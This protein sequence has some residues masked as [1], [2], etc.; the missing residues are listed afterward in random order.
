MS[1]AAAT[2]GLPRKGGIVVASNA[3]AYARIMWN[4]YC[5][6]GETMFEST[7]IGMDEGAWDAL[8][9]EGVVES[10]NTVK[11]TVI[12]DPASAQRYLNL[13]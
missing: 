11:G 2:A 5:E 6:T 12:L 9:S 7:A 4:R 3:R 8:E 1:V 10:M 13:R